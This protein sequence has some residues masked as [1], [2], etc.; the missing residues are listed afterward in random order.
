[1][2][3]E[4]TICDHRVIGVQSTIV[5]N[6]ADIS[7]PRVTINQTNLQ[8]LE[9]TDTSNGAEDVA[10]DQRGGKLRANAYLVWKSA[11]FTYTTVCNGQGRYSGSGGVS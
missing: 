11:G 4:Y 6:N 7:K 2:L 5:C 8:R 9:D 10:R 1:M 3:L